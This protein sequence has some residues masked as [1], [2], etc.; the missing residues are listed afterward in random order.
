MLAALFV[1]AI[2]FI[3]LAVPVGLVI[4]FGELLSKR[5]TRMVSR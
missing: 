2:L 4:L 1:V 3:R 5:H